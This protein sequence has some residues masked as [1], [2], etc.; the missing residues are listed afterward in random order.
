MPSGP[1]QHG[2]VPHRRGALAAVAAML[3][4]PACSGPAPH[5]AAGGS[6]TPAARTAG[7]VTSAPAARAP[8]PSPSP[9]CGQSAL[10]RLTLG[11]RV[12]QL[13]MVGVPAAD[14][15]A[16]VGVVRAYALGG[17][18]LAGRSDAGATATRAQVDR[19][20]RRSTSA[21]PV[22]LTVATDQEGGYVQ[23]LSGPGFDPVPTALQQGAEPAAQLRSDTTAWA[24]QLRAAGVT[25]DLA[26]VADT[27]ATG[28]G[29]ANLPIGAFSRE[30]ARTPDAVSARIRTV[31]TAMRAA[32]VGATVKHFPGLGRVRANTDTSTAA[33]DPVTGPDDPNLR[34]FRAGIAAGATAV[35]VSN[36]RYPRL[37]GPTLAVFSPA[38]ITGLLRRSWGYTGLVV[39]DD[40][41]RA[42]AVQQV[43]LGG[44]AVAFVAAGG[45]VVLTVRTA[46]AG[47]LAAA[48]LARARTDPSFRARVGDAALHVLAA[49]ARLGLIPCT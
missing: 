32:G 23:T 39:S 3:L 36:A 7:T 14:P 44:R 9:R 26:P 1:C 42:V 22:P 19:L 18:F 37:S 27:V 31:V 34:P 15:A 11:Q 47:T 38:V 35:M 4:L 13:L 17:V 43:P 45:D 29:A 20:Q 12:G 41:G 48:L 46:D 6:H 28:F 21:L 49:K 16:G 8:T 24:R 10:T 2:G 40:I 30:Y 5:P 33:V 25:L